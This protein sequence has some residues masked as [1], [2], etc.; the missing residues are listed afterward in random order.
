MRTVG[1]LKERITL[2][3]RTAVTDKGI[4]RND[5]T[6][7]GAWWAEIMHLSQKDWS[8]ASA[9]YTQEI[10]TAHLWTPRTGVIDT[11]AR[12]LWRGRAFEVLEVVPDRPIPGMT[13]LRAVACDM[14]GEGYA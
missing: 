11:G 12:L 13:E 8:A 6:D 7:V 14:E 3:K 1:D 4:S 9:T 10:I 2:Q 5:W